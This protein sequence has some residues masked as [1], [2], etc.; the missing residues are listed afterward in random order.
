MKKIATATA[1]QRARRGLR[2]AASTPSRHA[3]SRGLVKHASLQLHRLIPF[4]PRTSL[5]SMALGGTSRLHLMSIFHLF[6]GAIPS[7]QQTLRP[8]RSKCSD[9]A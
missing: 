5:K 4:R 2:G 1:N 6:P 7:V 9:M 3:A 8:L